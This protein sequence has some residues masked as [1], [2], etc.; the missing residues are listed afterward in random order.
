MFDGH[1]CDVELNDQFTYRT[2][3]MSGG[4]PLTPA[5]LC[6]SDDEITLERKWTRPPFRNPDR[7]TAS[8][9]GVAVVRP[10]ALKA[11]SPPYLLIA[12]EEVFSLAYIRRADLS[13][14]AKAIEST[15]VPIRVIHVP[16]AF[17]FNPLLL[18]HH[19]RRRG[20]LDG[21]QVV[22]G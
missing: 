7:I 10:E 16:A 6:V 2:K 8:G 17:T 15:S 22:R 12:D 14:I 13:R 20:E 18:A 9:G 19:L 1:G 21:L 5:V 3:A 4:N 11:W